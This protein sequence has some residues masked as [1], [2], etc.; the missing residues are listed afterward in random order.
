MPLPG[1]LDAQGIKTVRR[2]RL[3][4]VTPRVMFGPLDRVTAVLAACGWQIKT[5]FVERLTLTIRQHVAAVGRRVRPR[6]KSE[7]GVRQPLG[8]SS[9]SSHCCLPH[10]SLRQALPQSVPSKGTGSA[11]QWRP[12]TPARA[13]GLT[14][15]VGT[16]REVL[17]DRVPPWPPARRGVSKPW[18]GEAAR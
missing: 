11:T 16:W 2:Q 6:C 5:A 15:R 18:W 7:D 17:L 12:G 9:V 8:L 14:D 1:L 4:H 3:V 10:A 13:A